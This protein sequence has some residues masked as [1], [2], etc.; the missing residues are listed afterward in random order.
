MASLLY[1]NIEALSRDKGI[2][3]GIVV[4]AVEDAIA[5]ATRKYYKTVENMRAEL[6]KES[7]E[8]RAYIYKTVVETPELVEDPVNQITLDEARALAPGV[9]VG[10]EIRYYKPTD[11]LGRIAAQMAKQVIFQKVRE[12]ERDTVFLEYN[13]R[14]G[15]IMNAVVKRVE[16][17]DVI[18]DIGK[19]EARMPRREQSRLEQ[20]AVGERVRVVLLRVDRAA[21]GPQVIVSRA[22]PE[23][24]QNLFQSEVPEIYDGTVT[25]R[26]IARE[27]GERTKIA[28]Q[29]RD[30]DVDPV[31]ACVG[32]KGMR[33]QSIIRELRGEKI[34][35][36]EYSDEITTFAEKALQPAKVSRVSITDLTDKQIEVIVD[37]SQLSLAIG[38]KGQ[39]VRLAA[40]LLGW[41]I[42][43]KSE[44]EKRQEV[45]H[46]MQ[47]MSGGPS[48]PIEQ[49]TELGEQIIQKLVA[50]GITTV[51]ALADMT[52]EQL[53]EIP[54]IG[55]RT[56]EKIGTAV[57]HY[58]G[59]YEPGEEHAGATP[60]SHP[61]EEGEGEMAETAATTGELTEEERDR[62]ESDPELAKA[63]AIER[64]ATEEEEAALRLDNEQPQEEIPDNRDGSGLIV[65]DIAAQRMEKLTES[66]E[67]VGEFGVEIL[68]PGRDDTSAA[69]EQHRPHLEDG[70]LSDKVNPDE[71]E[72]KQED[73]D[74]V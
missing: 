14:V 46:Q 66:G 58:F 7:G 42:D 34:D 73:E 15:E 67:D 62:L 13:H 39:N 16:P 3:P 36:I 23:L 10:G 64:D 49:V 1:Q 9:E 17:Q 6:D 25:V 54:G 22:V 63:A 69:L 74:G 44:E 43:I 72:S 51:E 19:A 45:E 12:A 26:A 28:V 32:M 4:G 70:E 65:D 71:S 11:V 53:E 21:K 27:A 52:P 50:A 59:Q 37:D 20:F 40:K 68:T 61:V 24:V 56:L 35:I 33:V 5:L 60:A 30:K 29:S 47:Q 48:T 55:E 8:I 57:R 2:D 38:K 41:K 18:F 31:G